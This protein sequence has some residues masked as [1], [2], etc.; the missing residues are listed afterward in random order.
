MILALLDAETL[1]D[2]A[3][4]IDESLCQ[5]FHSDTT[6]LL[7]FSEHAE[8]Q[9]NLHLIKREDAAAIDGL[10]DQSQTAV[11]ICQSYRTVTV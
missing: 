8:E 11:V 1:D 6:A 2:V 5:D 4:A 10:V 3:V 7:L 9:N